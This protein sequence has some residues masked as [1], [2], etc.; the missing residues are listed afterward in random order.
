MVQSDEDSRPE[1]AHQ[2]VSTYNCALNNII[3]KELS[4]LITLGDETDNTVPE[5]A[6]RLTTMYS[7]VKLNFKAGLFSSTFTDFAIFYAKIP[8]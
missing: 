6:I 2:K 4:S 8:F 7:Y 1:R 5:G 3:L